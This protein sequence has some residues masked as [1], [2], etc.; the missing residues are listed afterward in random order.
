M[1][2]VLARV[3]L[4]ALGGTLAL[5]VGLIAGVLAAVLHRAD[6]ASLPAAVRAGGRAALTVLVALA[7]VAGVVVAAVGM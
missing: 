5:L 7:A 4:A 6:G 1:S 2:P 3:L